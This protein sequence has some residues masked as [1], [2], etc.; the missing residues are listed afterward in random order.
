VTPQLAQALRG[1]LRPQQR[2][3]LTELLAQIDGLDEHIARFTTPI[4]ATCAHDAAEAEVVA[5]LDTIPGLSEA[6]AQV[7][8]LKISTGPVALRLGRSAWPPGLAC[9]RVT[10][11]WRLSRPTRRGSD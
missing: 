6:T 4:Q 7:M 11:G 9:A 2:F 1:H 5:L 8:A 10:L 3:V